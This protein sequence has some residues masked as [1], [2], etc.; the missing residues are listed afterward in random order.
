MTIYKR[1]SSFWLARF[2]RISRAS[3]HETRQI[4]VG[5]HEDVTRTFY[6]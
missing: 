3:T 1:T 4:M 6:A 5:G 2:Y